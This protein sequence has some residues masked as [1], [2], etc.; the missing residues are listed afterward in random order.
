M[1]KSFL[2]FRTFLTNVRVVISNRTRGPFLN[3]YLPL[4]FINFNIIRHYAKYTFEKS[5]ITWCGVSFHFEPKPVTTPTKAW[6]CG[7][8]L[9]G[10]AGSNTARGM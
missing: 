7:R 6:V 1:H 2:N 3:S 5:L 4:K 9:A 8:S 10:I